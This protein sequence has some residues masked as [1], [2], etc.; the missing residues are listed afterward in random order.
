MTHL[1]ISS[2]P[3][4]RAVAMALIGLVASAASPAN[5]TGAKA[6]T[7]IELFTSQGCS[8]CPP[9]N[10]NFR[11]L[12]D[13]PGVLALSFSVTYWD[14]I[15]WK[16]TFASPA[17]TARQRAYVRP[18]GNATPFTPQIVVNGH[19]DVVGNR[20]GELDELIADSRFG[21]DAPTVK[22]GSRAVSVGVGTA[23]G[24][25]ADVWLVRYDPATV[26]VSVRRGENGGRTLPHKNVVHGLERIGR[27]NGSPASF[28]FS[29][30]RGGLKTAVLVQAP[31]GGPILGAATN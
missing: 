21:A 4:R 2:R 6:S 13:R 18:L 7:V 11:A 3:R 29:A 8:S 27:W 17:Y 15:G 1:Q 22:L 20:R 14:Y 31:Q 28:S 30:A 25:A 12:S 19:R 10:E 16:D 23:P 24:G 5:A 26:E 9:A